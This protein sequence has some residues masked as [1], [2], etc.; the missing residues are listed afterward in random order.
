MALEDLAH[1]QLLVAEMFT[2]RCY[3]DEELQV[4][5]VSGHDM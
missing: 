5:L 2:V 3:P 4:V 1:F